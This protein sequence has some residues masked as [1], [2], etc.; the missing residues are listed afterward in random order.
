M[1]NARVG[2]RAP[3]AGG[4]L[5]ATRGCKKLDNVIGGGT[6]MRKPPTRLL[7]GLLVLLMVVLI[8][9]MSPAQVAL[10]QQKVSLRFWMA[11]DPALEASMDEL[12]KGFMKANPSVTVQRDAFPFNEYHQ[13]ITTASAA[14]DAPDVF[15][16]DVRTAAFAAQGSLLVLTKYLTPQNK[17]D[18]IDSGL[19]EPVWKGQVYGVPMH[20]LTEGLFVNRAMFDEAGIKIPQK[21]E[22]AWTWDEFV[23]IARR[24]TKRTGD[25]TDVWGF[26]VLRHLSDWPMLP[27]IVQNNGAVLSPDLKK[28][29]GFLNGPATVEAM[30]WYQDLFTRHRV[31]AVDPIPDGFPTGRI[32]MFQAPSTYRAFLDRR[33]PDFKYAVVP[34]FKNKRCAV[35]A[36]GWNVSIAAKTKNPDV[37]WSLT[38]YLTREKHAE[39]VRSSGY[40][41][42][43]KSLIQKE[44]QFKQY[45]WDIFT[46]QLQKCAIHRPNTAAYNYFFDTFLAVAKDI[47]LGRDV[48]RTLDDAAGRLDV[49]LTRGGR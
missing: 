29:T 26:G 23:N 49:A 22:D 44:Q 41:P 36:G 38:D 16:M 19:I 6:T 27:V 37:A 35:T 13:K 33:F 42:V 28:A 8:V 3:A 48:Q 40:L 9:P 43:R 12:L 34:M 5:L 4:N 11:A 31:I 14:G 45:P 17:G 15:W 47:A 25:R 20:E 30:K 24:V 46:A 21:L 10:A 39:W 32:A 18:L 1:T 2:R 7:A